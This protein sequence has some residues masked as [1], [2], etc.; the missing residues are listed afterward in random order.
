MLCLI[1]VAFAVG[2][3]LGVVITVV[4]SM[5]EEKGDT[6]P[7]AVGFLVIAIIVLFILS[8]NADVWNY[9]YSEVLNTKIMK[10]ESVQTEKK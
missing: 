1:A 3:F 6:K 9:N 8:I 4:V 7:T 5:F 10:I 2:V